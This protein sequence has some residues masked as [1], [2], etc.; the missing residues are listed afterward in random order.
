[1]GKKYN[2]DLGDKPMF[3]HA[4]GLSMM[5]SSPAP[6]EW[7]NIDV[8]AAARPKGDSDHVSLQRL[9]PAHNICI[10]MVKRTHEWF[11]SSDF[12]KVDSF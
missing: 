10:W 2:D 6:L 1:M 4:Q 8:I 12:F 5:D 3:L 9:D 11:P 7:E